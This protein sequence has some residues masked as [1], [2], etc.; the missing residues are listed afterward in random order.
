[1]RTKKKILKDFLVYLD[2]TPEE[3]EIKLNDPNVMAK[4]E[5]VFIES[6]FETENYKGQEISTLKAF[7]LFCRIMV[8][9]DFKTGDYVWNS[10]VEKQFILVETNKLTC[11]MAARGHGKSFFLSLYVIFK[12]FI[13]SYFDVCYCSNTPKQTKRWFKTTRAIVDGNEMLLERKD[14]H[15]VKAKQIS[16][17]QQELEYNHGTL[18][19]TSMGT[20]P[21]GGH[22]NLIMGDDPLREDQKY[23]H[24]YI[25]NYF[26]GAYKQCMSRKKGR[27]IIVG[28]P[29]DPEDLFHTLMNSKVDKNNRPVGIVT[30]NKTS[31][32]GFYSMVFPGLDFK[33]K[34]VLV[35]EIW[36]YEELLSERDKIGEIRFNREIL[37]RCVSFKNSL[38]GAF[39]FKKCCDEKLQMIQSGEQGKKYVIFV[40]SA[41]SD[42]PS[43]DY[44]AM[45]VW[46]DDQVNNK[47]IFRNLFHKRGHPV[48]DPEGGDDDQ[49]NVLYR[50]W[51]DFNEALV[52]IEK[53]NAGIALIQSVKS[54][55]AKKQESIDMIEHLTHVASTVKGTIGKANDVIDYIEYGLKSGV[56]V[57]PSDSDDH[58]TMEIL[59]KVKTEHLNFG[60]KKGRGGGEKYE[61]IAG[62]DDIFDSCFG[63]FKY[64][65]DMADTLP[66]AVTL[67]G[68]I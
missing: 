68:G 9:H 58:Y 56:I 40:D 52:I 67:P 19:G 48:T 10:F 45:S 15:G 21:R 8:K 22:F 55:C 61:A 66:M 38:I 13:V 12:M 41:T 25:L 14:I 27:Y 37:C 16:W 7:E 64:R 17:G 28:T 44:C 59:D 63:A 32:T 29:Q 35:P 1:M 3:I 34:K 46:E 4:Y 18:E 24:E 26:Q 20:T 6:I 57:F 36:T 51:K 49:T 43:A 5:E 31:A 54:M 60:V 53:N 62:K 11:Y 2:Y 30:M 42:A 39:M 33:T 23:T 50:L 65:G 47:F